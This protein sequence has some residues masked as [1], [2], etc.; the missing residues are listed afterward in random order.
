[1]FRSKLLKFLALAGVVLSILLWAGVSSLSK[2]SPAS[3]SETPKGAKPANEN[4]VGND[5]CK[6]CHEDQTKNFLHT[7][8]A[9][10]TSEGS[11]K[12]RV[13]GCEWCQGRG[14]A[15][16]EEGDPAKII[17]FKN[18]SSKNISEPC[19]S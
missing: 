15:H 8:H 9:K 3:T 4:Y 1:M 7:A 10:L 11:W 12:R 6:D 13:T 17:S 5:A 2:S 14:K 16:V 19:L 18:K